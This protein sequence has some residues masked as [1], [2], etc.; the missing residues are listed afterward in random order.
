MAEKNVLKPVRIR[1]AV[2]TSA[3]FNSS[4]YDVSN[5]SVFTAQ[6]IWSGG[7]TPNGVVII[8]GSL[9]GTSWNTISS[10]TFSVTGSAGSVLV[11]VVDSGVRYARVTYTHTSG[12]HNSSIWISG[13]G[14]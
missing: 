4:A 11:N 9:N 2:A 12:S 3:T 8:E 13:K 7:S 5:I 14:F 6:Y 1:N 10:G